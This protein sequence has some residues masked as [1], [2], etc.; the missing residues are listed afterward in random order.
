MQVRENGLAGRRC[1]PCFSLGR[2]GSKDHS[3]SVL[4]GAAR[5][6]RVQRPNRLIKRENKLNSDPIRLKSDSDRV[7]SDRL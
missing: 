1:R 4:H 2:G 7:N 5:K 6:L 3:S